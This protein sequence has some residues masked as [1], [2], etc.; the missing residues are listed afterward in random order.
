MTSI[1]KTP[2]IVSVANRPDIMFL[3]MGF[4]LL[5]TSGSSFALVGCGRAIF[6]YLCNQQ[7]EYDGSGKT[8]RDRE[9]CAFLLRDCRS[10]LAIAALVQGHHFSSWQKPSHSICWLLF[11]RPVLSGERCHRLHV[12][13]YKK[14]SRKESRITSR[15]TPFRRVHS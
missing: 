15:N 7:I 5:L 12:C 9:A 8:R 11:V 4:H 13:C 3:V 10:N 1:G 2:V 6:Y 14:K